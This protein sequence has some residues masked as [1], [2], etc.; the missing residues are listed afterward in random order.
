MVNTFIDKFK[1][2]I[3]INIKGKNIKNFIK[4]I[5]NNKID[6]INQEYIN[7]NEV[8]LII[9]EKDYEKIIKQKT[10][11]E[12][13]TL[14]IYGLI[15][16]KKTIK[17]NK[18]VIVFLLIGLGIIIFLS[19]VIFNVTVVHNNKDIRELLIGELKNYDIKKGNFKKNYKQIQ[20]IKEEI[21]KKYK[22]KLEWIEIEES[23]TKYIVRVEERKINIKEEEPAKRNVVASKS[24][25]IKNI[26][27]DNGVIVKRLNDYV[28]KGD[29]IVSGEIK[30]NDEI[31]NIV[32]ANGKVYG[33]VWYKTKV[34]YPYTYKETIYTGNRKTSYSFKFLNNKLKLFNFNKFKTSKVIENILLKNNV[35]PISLIKEI[36]EETIV[37]DEIYTYEEVIDIASKRSIKQ[38]EDSLKEGE[39]ILKYNQLKI[40]AK[41]S[42]IVLEMFFSVYENITDYALINE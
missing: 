39:K 28:N 5:I 42:T 38:I 40:E 15:K 13:E 27:A 41:E 22:D 31:K 7:R 30:L 19:N 20:K 36:E 32:S 11:Y 4:K 14:Q 29:V 25:I 17:T 9:Y 10:I 35:F 33:E 3:K 34:E 21:L 2:S 26:V 23:G 8:N 24:A 16:I 1:S 6:I 18:Y 37:T 12:I